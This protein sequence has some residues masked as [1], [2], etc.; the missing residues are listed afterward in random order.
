MA[1]VDF[2]PIVGRYAHIEKQRIYY[3]EAGAGIPLL[4]L[5]SILRGVWCRTAIT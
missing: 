5:Q 2:E 1:E 4:C 3:E